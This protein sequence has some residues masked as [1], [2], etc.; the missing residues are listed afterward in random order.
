MLGMS[1]SETQITSQIAIFNN[2][3]AGSELPFFATMTQGI[4]RLSR[5]TDQDIQQI[6]EPEPSYCHMIVTLDGERALLPDLPA[7]EERCCEH[8][9]LKQ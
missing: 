5:I 9:G 8:L 4:P 7:I 1:P 6:N 2:T 3:L